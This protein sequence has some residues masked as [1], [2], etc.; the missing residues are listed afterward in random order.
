MSHFRLRRRMRRLV[1][2]LSSF[3]LPAMPTLAAVVPHHPSP[4][5][6]GPRRAH[7][8][9]PRLFTT[10]KR[11]GFGRQR[12]LAVLVTLLAL[13]LEVCGCDLARDATVPLDSPIG[14]FAMGRTP[15]A[16]ERLSFY[17]PAEAG[18]EALSASHVGPDLLPPVRPPLREAKPLPWAI[19][20]S[21]FYVYSG[22][23]RGVADPNR[24][25]VAT[26]FVLSVPDRRHLSFVRFL[27][28]ARHVVDPK[29]ADCPGENPASID[30]R[31]NR[32]AGG[33]GYETIPLQ[34]G[35]RQRFLTPSDATADV[36]IIPLD[37]NLIANL[38]DYKFLDVP[39]RLLPT[40]AEANE[41]RPEQP[42]ITARIP[43]WQAG[44]PGNFP[45]FD[46]GSLAEMP[47][48][49]VDVQCGGALE[50][51]PRAKPLHV[52]FINAGTPQGASGAPVY[53]AIAR[54]AGV[55]KTPVLLGIQSIAWP[56]V[57]M[58]GITPSLVLRELIQTSLREKQAN[59]DFYK[60]A[61]P[62][63]M[64]DA[65]PIY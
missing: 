19:P 24:Q 27:V 37:R 45:V 22:R 29:W 46:A 62:G 2:H 55:A 59:M 54:S 32:R 49:A 16:A 25:P 35:A 4:G 12:F 64:E 17:D 52:W 47:T 13:S 9:W 57:G 8:A 3:S 18:K 50:P 63:P 42:V 41:F 26:A 23:E 43:T 56:D 44:G 28:V 48:E 30:L 61:N 36:A 6:Y 11:S 15:P 33:I 40:E 53:T 58:V 65:P 1:G 7:F 60:G 14:S 39:F 21:V 20:E 34:S 31:L 38:N 10:R 51:Q 5:V